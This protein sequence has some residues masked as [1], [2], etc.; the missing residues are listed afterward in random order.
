MPRPVLR[1]TQAICFAALVALVVHALTGFGSG[2]VDSFFNDW[3]YDGLVLVSA[4]SCLVRAAR[5]RERRA[6]WLVLGLGLLCWTASEGYNSVYL[7]HLKDPP[8]PSLSDAL[9]LLFYPAGSLALLLLVRGRMRGARASLW[10]DGLVAAL[11]VCTIGEVT[12][13]H[14]VAVSGA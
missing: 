10:L 6:A 2:G 8:Y 11:A 5:V 9:A 1:T 3:V 7:A 12:G 4:L 14:Q 13:F